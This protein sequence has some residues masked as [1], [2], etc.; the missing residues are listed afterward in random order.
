MLAK[1]SFL[2]NCDASTG[3]AFFKSDFVEYQMNLIQLLF[4]FEGGK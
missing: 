3:A 1:S 4:C 2:A